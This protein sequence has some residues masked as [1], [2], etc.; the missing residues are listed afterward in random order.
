VLALTHLVD[1]AHDAVQGVGDE[2]MVD[3]RYPSIRTGS[4]SPGHDY[5]SLRLPRAHRV[6]S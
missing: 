1:A 6:F 4:G 5:G 2:G 3:R